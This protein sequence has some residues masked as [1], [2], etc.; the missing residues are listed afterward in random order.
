[1]KAFIICPNENIGDMLQLV[2]EKRGLV[3]KTDSIDTRR[4]MLTSELPL[5]EI[6]VDFHAQNQKHHAWL[7]LDGLRNRT[8]IARATW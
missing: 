1:V 5:N 3:S 6:V 8:A 7:R 2:M 4:V